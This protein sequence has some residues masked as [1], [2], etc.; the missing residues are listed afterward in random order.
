[1]ELE[2]LPQVI[3]QSTKAPGPILIEAVEDAAGSSLSPAKISIDAKSAPLRPSV[4]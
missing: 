1:M 2:S 3:V 4:S